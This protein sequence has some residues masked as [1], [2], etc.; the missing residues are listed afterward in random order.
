MVG[1]G[2]SRF[3]T[4]VVTMLI[5]LAWPAS[6]Q[7]TKGAAL[8]AAMRA[9]DTA[10]LVEIVEA[11]PDRDAL[12]IGRTPLLHYAVMQH[13]AGMVTALL[14]AGLDVN[15]IG[16]RGD[17]ALTLAVETDAGDVVT[18]LLD[19]NID[20]ALTGR[21]GLTAS[22]IAAFR[23]D[24]VLAFQTLPF[25]AERRT[26]ANA[27]LLDAAAR[28]DTEA[29][30]KAVS[31]GADLDARTPS[32]ETVLQVGMAA[33]QAPTIEFLSELPS[34]LR[35]KALNEGDLRSLLAFTIA[36]SADD[37]MRRFGVQAIERLVS[38]GLV[39][40]DAIKN[41]LPLQ[42]RKGSDGV[43]RDLL[44]DTGVRLSVVD[45]L[46]PQVVQPLPPLE[47]ELRMDRPTGGP[48]PVHWKRIQSTLKAEGLYDGKIDGLPGKGTYDGILAYVMGIAPL[49]VER[50]EYAYH[51][52]RD[53]SR[54]FG[55]T[56]TRR[57]QSDQS[58]FLFGER[59]FGVSGPEAV[60]YGVAFEDEQH[61]GYFGHFY[62]A[63]S[64]PAF[65]PNGWKS[66]NIS[67][68]DCRDGFAG[69]IRA[70]LLGSSF[71]I[72][73]GEDPGYEHS[74]PGAD[75]FVSGDIGTLPGVA[76]K[77]VF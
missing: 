68:R 63:V 38:A 8:A 54:R 3:G 55:R 9:Q 58:I 32:G 39:D 75:R 20:R 46:F 61:S 10:A 35:D 6:A 31:A 30:K 65:R 36:S 43:E 57:S 4:A 72:R 22:E 26:I 49:V 74:L 50:A 19:S 11:E 45:D 23:G 12:R 5:S 67:V 52:S 70:T 14:E 25:T 42:R 29:L 16:P 66:R 37:R 64:V 24:T 17:T 13:D 41:A 33:Q 62:N 69:E 53:D 40:A 73:L 47:Y 1:S 7:D 59:I 21:A 51:R 27:W 77:S 44:L 28:G 56:S 34:W 60:G 71:V 48:K 18:V 76:C 15:A 2:R